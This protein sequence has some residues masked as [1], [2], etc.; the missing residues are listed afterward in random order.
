MRERRLRFFL[1]K[2]WACTSFLW[3]FAHFAK[4]H[5]WFTSLKTLSSSRLPIFTT[6][7]GSSQPWS[8]VLHWSPGNVW[9]DG[10]S[11]LS[12]L[13]RPWPLPEYCTHRIDPFFGLGILLVH[14]VAPW[15]LL[16]NLDRLDWAWK[17][18][19]KVNINRRVSRVFVAH[20]SDIYVSLI[21]WGCPRLTFSGFMKVNISKRVFAAHR[22]DISR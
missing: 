14:Y 8:P 7:W 15:K 18:Y 13:F 9:V 10:I 2:V 11:H 12:L 1:L 21:L 20:R 22:S 5:T 17:M 4:W 19:R 6:L 3:R 16:C